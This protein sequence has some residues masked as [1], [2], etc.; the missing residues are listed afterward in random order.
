MHITFKPIYYAQNYASIIGLGLLTA[1][2][3]RF[4]AAVVALWHI[5]L[6]FYLLF[7]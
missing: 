6:H 4:V 3:Q 5:M 1:E 7:F 2:K